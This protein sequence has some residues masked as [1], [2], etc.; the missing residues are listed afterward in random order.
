MK[1][2]VYRNLHFEGH[3]YSLKS[4]EGITR[5]RVIGHARGI[6]LKNVEFVVNENGRQRVLK[7]KHKNVHAGIVGEVIGLYD[8]RP[9][10]PS[11]LYSNDP[12]NDQIKGYKVNYNPYLYSSFVI[13]RSKTPIHKADFVSLWMGDI[14]VLSKPVNITT[15]RYEPQDASYNQNR[16]HRY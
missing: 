11:S 5:G 7:E 6:V 10:M 15:T 16:R 8:Y 1:V 12:W 14:R 3:V 9:R 2:F 13:D 4:L